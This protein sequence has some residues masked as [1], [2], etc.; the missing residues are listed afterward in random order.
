MERREF[1]LST[2]FASLGGSADWSSVAQGRETVWEY[3]GAGNVAR[4]GVLTPDFD[5]VPESELWA[6]AP[7]GISVHTSRIPRAGG[8]GAGF[9]AAPYADDAVDRLVELAPRAILLGYTSSSYALGAEA[10]ERAR[11]RL[12][13][14]AKGIDV[15][16][17]CGAAD[18]AFRRL[19]V[20]RLSVI[21]PPWWTE[22]ANEQ[23]RAYWRTAGFEVLEC[24]RLEPVGPTFTE[25]AAQKVFEFVRAKTP[26]TADA[27]FIGGNG[28]RA[29]GAVRALEARLRRPVLTANQVLLC[30]ALRRLGRADS[31]TRYGRIFSLDG[32]KRS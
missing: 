19:G 16:F 15:I 14:R 24:T 27:V 7:H 18:A 22:E 28:M 26:R 5:P 17:T 10:D 13:E 9:V 29:I 32:G 25:V 20:K 6:M 2:A 8:R 11:A 30:E 21:H 12:Q 23:G 31:V 4:L 1:L 3:D